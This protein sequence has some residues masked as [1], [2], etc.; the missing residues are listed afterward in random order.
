MITPATEILNQKGT[1]MFNSD[2]FANRPAA[3]IAGRIFISTDTKELYRDTGTTWELLSAGGGGTVTGT[4]SAT[5]VAF[6]TGSSAIGGNNDLWWDNVNDYLGIKTNSPISELDVV[7]QGYFHPSVTAAAN[8]GW[9]SSYAFTTATIP[10]T[11]FS[12]LGNVFCGATG[13]NSMTYNGD[14]TFQQANVPAAVIGNNIF[15]FGSGGLTIS[16]NQG[17]GLRAFSALTAFNQIQSNFTGTITH[18]AGV[19]VL[20]PFASNQ[21]MNVTNYYGLLINNATERTAFTITNRWGIYQDGSS[22]TNYFAGRTL[23]R[24]NVDNGNALQVT[25]TANITNLL[26][27]GPAGSNPEANIHVTAAINLTPEIRITGQGTGSARL[28]LRTLAINACEFHYSN[29]LNIFDT[30]LS[31]NTLVLSS[32]GNLLVGSN[33]DNGARLQVTGNAYFKSGNAGNLIL[34]NDNSRYIQLLFQRNSIANTGGDILLDGTDNK[35]NIRVLSTASFVVSTS[36]SAGTPVERLTISNTGAATFSSNVGIG[37][38]PSAWGSYRAIDIGIGGSL[39]STDF[40]NVVLNSNSYNT[41]NTGWRY[42]TTGYRAA[43]YEQYAGGHSWSTAPS[44][45]AGNAITFTQAMTLDA[46]G[47]LLVGGTTSPSSTSV[48]LLINSSSGGFSGFAFNN[49]GG[50]A[51]GSPTS[52]TLA[53]YTAT[54]S[55]GAESYSE[56]MRITSGG[57]VLIGSATDTGNKLYLN[58]SLR[59]DGQRSG[60]A[61]GASGQHLII[62]LDGI[63]YKIALLNP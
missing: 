23:I 46:S 15:R 45:T 25:G 19:H 9:A 38:T 30:S 34:D 44:G 53:L 56:A 37:V 29:G 50:G 20:A 14:A 41:S 32:A 11:T 1:P 21:L 16:L 58:G 31:T 5:Q 4:G 22:D 8:A 28:R 7:G 40:E 33:T 39:A 3:G 17:S 42:R 47:R 26:G 54:G 57:N 18:L 51:I 24:S 13:I 59:I 36:A 49:N 35:F 27:V 52:S 6:W 43:L 10:A 55:I 60:T 12:N 62:T 48:R 63:Q 61:G 2:L